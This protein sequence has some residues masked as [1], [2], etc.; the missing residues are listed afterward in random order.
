MSLIK[1]AVIED[2]FAVAENVLDTD[3]IELLVQEVAR[4]NNS[5]FAK[6]RYNSTYAIRNA[7]LISEIH[8]L[9]CSQPIIA[10]ANTVIHASARPVKT[11]LFDKT[12]SHR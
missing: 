7:L 1:S 12:P 9:A 2:G 11:I 4:A 8:S 3:N 10:L 5:T 6:Q